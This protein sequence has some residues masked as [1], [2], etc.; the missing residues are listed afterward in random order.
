MTGGEALFQAILDAP[1]TPSAVSGASRMAWNG[2]A[3]ALA[4]SLRHL[5]ALG[6]D[7]RVPDDAVGV[8]L[9]TPALPRLQ[10]LDLARGADQETP[11]HSRG[12]RRRGVCP[13]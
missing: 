6:L 1:A 11:R 12:R 4:T 9:A 5:V 8:L 7:E 2:V 10:T 13:R 3:R